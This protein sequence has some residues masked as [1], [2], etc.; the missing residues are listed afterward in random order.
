MSGARRLALVEPE[1]PDSWWAALAGAVRGEFLA[2]P[3][4]LPAGSPLAPSEC[5]VEGCPRAGE[6]TP[7]G[8]FDTRLCGAH[9]QKWVTDGKPACN[10]WLSGQLPPRILRPI[11]RCSVVVCARS[12]EC[13]GLCGAHRSHWVQAGRPA[14]ERF[15]S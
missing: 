15:A 7:W 2:S 8:R 4:V 11:E 9:H 10:D 5:G 14:L 13:A 3:L 6:T 1:R 12:V